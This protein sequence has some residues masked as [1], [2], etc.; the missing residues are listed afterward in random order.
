MAILFLTSIY[1]SCISWHKFLNSYYFQEPC[2]IL[3]KYGIKLCIV[4][5]S[6]GSPCICLR[7]S[8]IAI[9]SLLEEPSSAALQVAGNR[10]NADHTWLSQ[11]LWGRY[12]CN[13][14]L[15]YTRFVLF[16]LRTFFVG[17]CLLI[18]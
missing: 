11:A 14:M 15:V 4:M 1:N 2:I 10:L 13:F 5:C 17:F 16:M 8:A 6:P 3:F 12:S 9:A 18:E 7:L